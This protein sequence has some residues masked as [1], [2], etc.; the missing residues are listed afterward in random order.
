M[1][2]IPGETRALIARVKSGI[3]KVRQPQALRDLARTAQ[4]APKVDAGMLLEAAD[5]LE[6]GRRDG[7]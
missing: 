1:I 4:G 5:L 6:G 3:A 2:E 7:R